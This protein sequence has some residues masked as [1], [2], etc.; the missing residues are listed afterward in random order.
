MIICVGWHRTSHDFPGQY[1][2][3][4]KMVVSSREIEEENMRKAR[5]EMK[6]VQKEDKE[7]ENFGKDK[8]KK[9]Q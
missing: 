6:M 3:L 2:V 4:N 9:N 5:L 1:M 8:K 7:L